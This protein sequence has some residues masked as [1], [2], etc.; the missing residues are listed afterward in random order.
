MVEVEEAEGEEGRWREITSDF[1][2]QVGVSL[3][4][5]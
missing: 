1:W 5:P 3:L 2:V 4:P